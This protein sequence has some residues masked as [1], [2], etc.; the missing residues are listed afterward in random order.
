MAH[1]HG[2]HDY[3]GNSCHDY[4][5]NIELASMQTVLLIHSY[6]QVYGFHGYNLSSALIL[7]ATYT[8]KMPISEYTMN[9]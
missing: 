9:Y 2:R 8:G 6:L 1:F 3:H 7:K 5:K 4:K